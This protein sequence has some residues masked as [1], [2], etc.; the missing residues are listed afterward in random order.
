MS[1]CNYDCG[2]DAYQ[3]MSYADECMRD[4]DEYMSYND[5]YMSYADECMRMVMSA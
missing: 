1:S 3:F 5:E 4:A 2:R